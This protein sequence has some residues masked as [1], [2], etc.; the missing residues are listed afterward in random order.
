MPEINGNDCRFW[1]KEVIP[2]GGAAQVRIG[3]VGNAA[4]DNWY[5]EG[6][7]PN[8]KFEVLPI[9]SIAWD[10]EDRLITSHDSQSSA[11]NFAHGTRVIHGT[12]RVRSFVAGKFEG[13]YAGSDKVGTAGYAAIA[14]VNPV[15]GD[16]A[17]L[18]N[19]APVT[20]LPTVINP[21]SFL[22][23]EKTSDAT[24]KKYRFKDVHIDGISKGFGADGVAERTVKFVASLVSAEYKAAGY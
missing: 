1:A 21:L 3:G 12:I 17:G 8:L 6:A 18:Y 23:V 10:E 15:N 9:M 24:P 16:G 14:Y 2:G 20:N 4:G 7:A 19:G 13:A 22:V 5:D 11:P